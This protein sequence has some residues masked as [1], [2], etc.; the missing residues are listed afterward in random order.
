M[1]QGSALSHDPVR[2]GAWRGTRSRFLPGAP[3]FGKPNFIVHQSA[4]RQA[5][6]DRAQ[7]G[8][9]RDWPYR[10]PWSAARQ[11]GFP[12]SLPPSAARK[13]GAR[14]KLRPAV[15]GG[16]PLDRWAWPAVR[17]PACAGL[18]V[19]GVEQCPLASCGSDLHRGDRLRTRV[20][21]GLRTKLCDRRG[22]AT[23]S[24]AG[25][26]HGRPWTVKSWMPACSHPVRRHPV[27]R[28]AAEF[29]PGSLRQAPGGSTLQHR[30]GPPHTMPSG[31]C[32]IGRRLPPRA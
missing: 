2:K 19:S 27:K 15:E 3:L 18:V 28:V 6:R 11:G 8:R 13:A 30:P 16:D 24:A 10:G 17:I 4:D 20:S 31:S 22:S 26:V 25:M 7:V 32:G 5:R 29:G 1:K 14:D 9:D 12:S 23:C 21:H